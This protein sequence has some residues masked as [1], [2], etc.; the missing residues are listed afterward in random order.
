MKYILI[1]VI[2]FTLKACGTK[3]TEHVNETSAINISTINVKGDDNTISVVQETI[4]F[5][6]EKDSFILNMLLDKPEPTFQTVGI[7]KYWVYFYK[8]LKFTICYYKAV[9]YASPEDWHIHANAKDGTSLLFGIDY[10]SAE[11]RISQQTFNKLTN[12]FK[13]KQ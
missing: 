6:P 8:D 3:N 2:A 12:Y 4:S 1:L 9:P 7:R 11:N 10:L 5:N 13:D